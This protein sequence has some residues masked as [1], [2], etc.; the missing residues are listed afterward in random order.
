MPYILYESATL[1]DSVTLYDGFYAQVIAPQGL[2]CKKAE[3]SSGARIADPDHDAKRTNCD[4][5]ARRFVQ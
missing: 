1:Y 2:T 5:Q 4:H 3:P